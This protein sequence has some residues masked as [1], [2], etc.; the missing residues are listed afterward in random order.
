MGNIKCEGKV[1]KS[2][3]MAGAL[4][5]GLPF[6]QGNLKVDIPRYGR[7]T[8]LQRTKQ[9]ILSSTLWHIFQH[10]HPHPELTESIISETLAVSTYPDINL[11]VPTCTSPP[12]PP[13]PK[14]EPQT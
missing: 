8:C 11:V 13:R 1:I 2:H 14:V 12:L 4:D 5:M 3:A 9:A 7:R 10:T 6:C